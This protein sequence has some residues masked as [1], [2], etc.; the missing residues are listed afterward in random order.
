MLLYNPTKT[1]IYQDYCLRNYNIG[2]DEAKTFMDDVGEHLYKKHK[3][4]GLVIL[5]YDEKAEA[6]YGSLAE[7]KKAKAIEGL[8]ILLAKL[9]ELKKQEAFGVKESIEKNA[10]P[11]ISMAFKVDEFDRQMK[12]VQSQ[13]MALRSEKKTEIQV[14]VLEEP[15]RRGRPPMK[16][17]EPEAV[18][19]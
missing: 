6:E 11:E 13:I 16:K 7:Y 1:I 17:D 10:S 8:G 19:A 18:T 3:D 12:E 14:P 2:P 4:F 15:K 5:N 9:D